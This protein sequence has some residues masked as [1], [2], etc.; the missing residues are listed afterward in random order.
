MMKK[1]LAVIFALFLCVALS[2]TAFAETSTPR[3][4]DG[5][6]LLTETEE[7]QLLSRMDAVSEKFK[8]EIVIATFRSIDGYSADEY[9]EFYYDQY[10]FGYGASRDGVL[11][12][13]DMG[14][15]DYRILSNGLGAAAISR[16]DIDTIGDAVASYLSD[17]DYADAFHRFV[18]ECEYE[19]NGQINGFPFD[20]STSLW[21]SLIVGLVVGLIV[22]G[23]M[24]GQLKSVRRQPAATEY[25]K[26]G[27]MQVTV[28]RDIF[29]Y[30]TISR[31]K[32]E[33]NSGRSSGSSGSS[34]NIGGG[35]F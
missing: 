7:E 10:G 28:A 6:D 17:G 15:R 27:S 14:E 35:K 9:V 23:V 3:L 29:L 24:I 2:V 1:L 32:K 34:R 8:V 26:R 4:F 19:I 30:R 12:L 31:Q 18:D 33:S 25:V 11:L 5:A 20:A 16:D 13:V 21:I 22:T